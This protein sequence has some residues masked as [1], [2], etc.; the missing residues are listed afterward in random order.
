MMA[1]SGAFCTTHEESRPGQHRFASWQL[2]QDTVRQ[3]QPAATTSTMAATR[4]LRGEDDIMMMAIAT[5]KQPKDRKKKVLKT[6]KISFF[7]KFSTKRMMLERAKQ[8]VSPTKAFWYVPRQRQDWTE[9]ANN[10]KKKNAARRKHRCTAERVLA[11]VLFVDARD[12]DDGVLE[13]NG[14]ATDSAQKREISGRCWWRRRRWRR[15]W[16]WEI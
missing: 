8:H 5:T 16:W 10:N 2:P 6:Q 11:G 1:L 14:D 7:Q 3:Q 15:Y 13:W 12:D 4:K 9:E